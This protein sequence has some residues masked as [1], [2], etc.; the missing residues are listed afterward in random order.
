M[1]VHI[2]VHIGVHMMGPA[3]VPSRLKPNVLDKYC[4]RWKRLVR[5]RGRSYPPFS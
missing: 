5:A 3:I 1:G 2:G 4:E